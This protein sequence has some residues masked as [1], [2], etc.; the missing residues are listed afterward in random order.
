MPLKPKFRPYK[1]KNALLQKSL[2]IS[3]PPPSKLKHDLSPVASN[4]QE[5]LGIP[6][7]S[8]ETY[9]QIFKIKQSGRVDSSMILN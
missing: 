8:H 9:D 1:K 4:F 5:S 7:I 3:P 6:C 2:P